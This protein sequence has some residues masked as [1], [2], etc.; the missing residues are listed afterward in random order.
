MDAS[1][2]F[3]ADKHEILNRKEAQLCKRYG[4]APHLSVIQGLDEVDHYELKDLL[5]TFLELRTEIMKL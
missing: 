5:E 4:V 3:R 2:K 1:D